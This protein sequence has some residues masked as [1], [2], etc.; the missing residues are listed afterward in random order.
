MVDQYRSEA[1]AAPFWK[2]AHLNDV[3]IVIDDAGG[4]ER[5]GSGP[6]IEYPQ[7]LLGDEFCGRV[8]GGGVAVST[9]SSSG[10]LFS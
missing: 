7:S 1:F 5:D 10:W 9:A 2:G 8:P 6:V 4:D 3:S